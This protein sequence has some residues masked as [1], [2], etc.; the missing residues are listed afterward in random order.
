MV[1]A[2]ANERQAGRR[3]DNAMSTDYSTALRAVGLDRYDLMARPRPALFALI[4]VF[5]VVGVR[6]PE[7]RNA[8]GALVSAATA[9]GLTYF[10]ISLARSQGRA[11]EQRLGE[12]VGRLHS[13]R[14][15]TLEDPTLSRETKK[16]YHAF[17]AKKGLTLSALEEERADPA[18][19]FDRTRSAADWLLMHA[20]PD[21]KKTLLFEDN[22]AYGFM[23]N[24][25]GLKGIAIGIDALMMM[26]NGALI[27]AS[28][29]DRPAVIGG[30][31]IE[32][33]LLVVLLL[34]IFFV[35]EAAVAQAS[36]AYA[37]RLFSLCETC[38]GRTS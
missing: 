31:L 5:L 23:R 20:K 16:R 32:I 8:V 4:P 37:Q 35:T 13:A 30:A 10:L 12:R 36:L 22:I 14:L 26:A 9:C 15:L 17:L 25:R 6:V 3:R 18:L 11:L 33:A 7:V 29:A 38:G 28:W 1:T 19:A 34:W 21:A 2:E 24:L 27:A